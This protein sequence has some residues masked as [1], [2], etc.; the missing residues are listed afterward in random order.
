MPCSFLVVSV[1]QLQRHHMHIRKSIF[2]FTTTLSKRQSVTCGLLD[3]CKHVPG[4]V[5]KMQFCLV[6]IFRG[7]KINLMFIQET[8]LFNFREFLNN[9]L[10]KKTVNTMDLILFFT[11]MHSALIVSA[12][13][14][15]YLL[16]KADI[17]LTA[18]GTSKFIVKLYQHKIKYNSS[19]EESPI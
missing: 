1:N 2:I 7:G 11:Q 10:V 16:D 4:V 5:S 18:G 6:V 9:L 19:G 3:K 17:I 14:D 13:L 12:S 8:Q 15:I